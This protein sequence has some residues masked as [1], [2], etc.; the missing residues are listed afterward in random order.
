MALN[1]I[2][3][4]AER[5]RHMNARLPILVRTIP[6]G[7]WSLISSYRFEQIPAY[8]ALS[9]PDR[10]VEE[11]APFTRSRS[12]ISLVMKDTCHVPIYRVCLDVRSSAFGAV[13]SGC[14]TSLSCPQVS[15]PSIVS[16]IPYYCSSCVFLTLFVSP[17][18]RL[19]SLYIHT[20]G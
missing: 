18:S 7:F 13:M 12:R 10:C 8:S 14:L 19:R 20:S 2:F 4:M 15:H 11:S 16:G 9:I 17:S 5:V 1:I 3:R 6:A